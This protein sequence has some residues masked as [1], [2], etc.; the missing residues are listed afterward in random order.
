MNVPCPPVDELLQLLDGEVTERRAAT[1][2]LHVESCPACSG[3]LRRSQQLLT[4]LAAP[5]AGTRTADVEGVMRRLVSRPP[6]PP[7]PARPSSKWAVVTATLSALAACVL[8]FIYLPRSEEGSF[9]ARGTVAS[10]AAS[11]EWAHRVGVDFYAVRTELR[12]LE[13]NAEV[14]RDTPLLGVYRNLAPTEAVYL[15][16]FAVDAQG[17]VHWL[18]PAYTDASKDPASIR[19]YPEHQDTPL[20]ETVILDAPAPGPA[21][22]VTVLSREPLHVSEIES[23]P[24]EQLSLGALRA[25]LGEVHVSEWPLLFSR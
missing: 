24:P 1:L 18:Y 11:E 17:T 2:R 15:L 9:Q 22:L 8:A 19:L 4:R 21:R 3:E 12:R 25:R 7:R 23:L 20:P 16:A 5:L 13:K 10:T 14:P 6:L